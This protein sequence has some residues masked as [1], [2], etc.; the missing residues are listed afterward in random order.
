MAHT[1]MFQVNSYKE[2]A[3]L[4]RQQ[5]EDDALPRAPQQMDMVRKSK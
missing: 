3:L 4:A 1:S 2:K 5:E